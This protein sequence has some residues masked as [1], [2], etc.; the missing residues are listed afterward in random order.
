MESLHGQ[1]ILGLMVMQDITCVLAIAI[2]AAFDPR[3]V[4]VDV[5]AKILKM[6]K[7]HLKS[8]DFYFLLSFCSSSLSWHAFGG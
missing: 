4:G 2:M 8:L 1:I 7:S 6:N 5:G 3:A